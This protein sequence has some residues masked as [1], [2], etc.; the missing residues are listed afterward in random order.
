MAKTILARRNQAEGF[1]LLELLVVVAVISVIASM[2]VPALNSFRNLYRLNAGR[3]ELIGV[4]ETA[5][6]SAI[7][8]DSSTTLT[9]ASSQEYRIQYLV[10]GVTRSIA[11]SLPAGVSFSLPPE[12]ATIT[13]DC[14]PSGKVTMTGSNGAALT[15]LTIIN[16]AGSRTISINV[17]GNITL[18]ATS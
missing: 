6:S 7:K 5:R 16:A 11:Y 13:I 17:A 18:T 1:S 15:S 10:N 12:I 4:F 8:L 3:D 9:I 2:S 14:R